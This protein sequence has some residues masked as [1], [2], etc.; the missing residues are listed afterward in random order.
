MLTGEDN[1]Q[2][3]GPVETFKRRCRRFPGRHAFFQVSGDQMR[4]HFGVGVG[5]QTAALFFQFVTQFLEVLDDA[6][7]DHG[8]LVGGMRVGVDLVGNAVCRPAG[9]ADT[10]GAGHRFR[11]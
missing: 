8:D 6:V 1:G 4:H 11:L 3:K 9:M 7:V 10:D 2:G 5:G